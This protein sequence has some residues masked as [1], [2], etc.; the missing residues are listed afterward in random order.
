MRNFGR[1][2]RLERRRQGY[3][4]EE[5]AHAAGLDRSYVGAIERGEQNPSLFTI[6]RLADTLDLSLSTLLETANI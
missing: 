3:S 1:A 2:L 6:A 4:Q 5:F